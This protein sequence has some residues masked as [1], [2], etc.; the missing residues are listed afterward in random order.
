MARR[1]LQAS[2][3]GIEKAKRAF[4][5]KQWTQEYL[6]CEVGIETRQPIWKFFK[7]K[8]VD[9]QIF[10]E[11]CFRLDLD[12]QEV[13]DRA[14]QDVLI[15]EEQNNKSNIDT[16]VQEVRSLCHQRIEAKCGIIR[17]LDTPQPNE[18]ED[19][20]VNLDILETITNQRWLDISELESFNTQQC[21]CLSL[22]RVDPKRVPAMQAVATN[23]KLMIF[24]K[25]GSG[26]TALLQHI[27]MKC[28]RGEFLPNYIPIFIRLK[29]FAE[30]ASVSENFNLLSYIS[31]ELGRSNI[32]EQQIETLLNHGKAIILL[33]GLDELQEEDR[34]EVVKQIRKLSEKYYKNHFII[35]CRIGAQP[36]QFEEFTDIEIADFNSYQIEAFAQKW[37]VNLGKNSEAKGK[38]LAAQ[39]VQKLHLTENRQ[40]GEL[41]RTP[42]LL[43]L[44]CS[45]FQAKLDFPAKRSDI[46]KQALD[47]ML[48]RWDE[49]KGVKRDEIYQQLSLH[50]KLKLLN[51]IA[52]VTFEQGHYFFLQ[53]NVQHYIVDYLRTLPIAQTDPEELQLISEAV[54]KSISVQNGLLVEQARGVYSF[55]HLTF[56]EYLTARNIVASFEPQVIDKNL[57]QLTSHMT[58]PRWREVFLLTAGMLENADTLMQLMQQHSDGL[59]AVDEKLQQF[60]V[61]LHQKSFSVKA[62]YKEAAIRAFYLTLNLPNE[63]RLSR[64][65]SLALAIDLRLADNLAPDM[66]ID[67]A[68]NRAL[69]LS[70]A[71]CDRPSLEQFLALNF[72]LSDNRTFVC[73]PSLSDEAKLSPLSESL[74][75]LKEQLPAFD[76][77]KESLEEWWNVNGE[78]W[79]EKLKSLI[80]KYRN[81]GYQWQFNEQ[82][83][84]V[85]QQYYA[86]KYLLVDCLKSG[87]H[88]TSTLRER[89]ESTFLLPMS[90]IGD[91]LGNAKTEYSQMR[92]SQPNLDDILSFK[93]YV[94]KN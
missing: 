6:A 36:Y 59:M 51:Q 85:L 93:D 3:V 22:D 63:L 48:V 24:G 44:V 7:G 58:D 13:A 19:I 67:L 30:D 54:L 15:E 2:T 1:S 80:L 76:R 25:P 83:K 75:L 69:S 56:Q 40:I 16:L 65:L 8:P 61:W 42:L 11:I 82:Q 52:T 45:V 91:S 78:I 72:A 62:P 23:P 50:H 35:T 28:D 5:R 46:Y 43:H 31:S 55:S 41:A 77:G 21:D 70:L 66:C 88:V 4:K 34:D 32:S 18:L 20:Y 79:V 81:I 57:A 47:I 68:L 38:A 12:W 94:S 71:L 17:L 60:L 26:K 53:S 39:F 90:E 37:F 10:Y 84:K 14:N 74:Q 89:I 27:A 92:F 73:D 49:A 87:C 86:G 33:D 64:N 9:R 29:N